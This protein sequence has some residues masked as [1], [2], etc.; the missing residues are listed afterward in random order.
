FYCSV[1]FFFFSSRRRHTRFSRDWSSDVCSS[2][3]G[4]GVGLDKGEG[5]GAKKRLDGPYGARRIKG[6]A[7]RPGEDDKHADDGNGA[8]RKRNRHTQK[9]EDQQAREHSN[10]KG[11]RVHCY[12]YLSGTGFAVTKAGLGRRRDRRY[13]FSGSG[14]P[15]G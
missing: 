5:V 8:K 11:S 10:R 1:F 3:L 4:E 15:A 6:P 9:Q 14:L 13:A 7:R 2:D 12:S